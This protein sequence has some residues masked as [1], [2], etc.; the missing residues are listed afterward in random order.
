MGVGELAGQKRPAG[1]LAAGAGQP[2]AGLGFHWAVVAFSAWMMGGAYLDGWAHAH[3]PQLE[4]F[5]TPWHGVL[6]SGYL[7]LAMLLT[8]NYLRNLRDGYAWRHAV[9]IGY[10]LSLIG[11]LVFALGGLGDMMWHQLFGIEENIEA[12]FSPTHLM[13]AVGAG[14]MVSGPLRAAWMQDEDAAARWRTWLPALL[15]LVL[16]YTVLAFM[17]QPYQPLGFPIAAEGARPSIAALFETR[18]ALGIAGILLQTA[19]SMGLVLLMLRRWSPP[20]GSLTLFFGIPTIMVALM[21]FRRLA[22]GPFPM[23]AAGILAGLV[24]DFLLWQL[25]PSPARRATFR[26]FAVAVPVALYVI[27]FSALLL[28][29]GI[30]WTVHLWTG[31]IVIAGIAGWLLSYLVLP[32]LQPA[33][34]P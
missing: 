27:Y 15:S 2:A 7:V 4:S 6:Y 31:S 23:V 18:Q 30:W 13:L 20:V 32:P 9:P 28:S 11:A 16:F 8:G 21:R 12:L 1:G 10:E 5:F 17:L 33:Q 3:I 22:T 14:L 34:R 29:G 19:L 24:A 26:L 25:K